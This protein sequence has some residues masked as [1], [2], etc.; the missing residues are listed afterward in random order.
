[1]SAVAVECVDC[2]RGFEIQLPDQDSDGYRWVAALAKR[3]PRCDPCFLR[4]EAEADEGE[5]EQARKARRD[6]CGL[7]QRLRGETLRDL[8]EIAKPGQRSALGSA[9][10]W[11]VSKD[12]GGLML[13][14]STGVGKTRIAAAACWTRLE[15][16]SCTYASVARAM[17]KL[18]GSFT[19]EG[20]AEAVRVFS[21]NGAVVLDDLDKSRPTDFGL[22]QIFSA[23]DAREQAGAP[24]LVTTNLTPSEIG[25]R[26]GEPLMSR[27]A[28]YCRTVRV[29]GDDWRVAR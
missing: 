1:M 17:A 7:P 16:F 27:L 23:V 2:G 26:Y 13:A 24:L 12:P 25:E 20:R 15:R 18:G 28:G 11:A 21:G 4:H 10:D 9:R 5:R 6:R 29:D 3:Q 14:G 22:E 19:D 8:W